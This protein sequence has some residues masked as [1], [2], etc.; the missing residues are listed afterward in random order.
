V[1]WRVASWPLDARRG[2]RRRWSGAARCR[3]PQADDPATRLATCS[4]LAPLDDRMGTRTLRPKRHAISFRI[5]GWILIFRGPG[6]DGVAFVPGLRALRPLCVSI[7]CTSFESSG[8]GATYILPRPIM[9][10]RI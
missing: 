2:G 10:L 5:D 1:W 6:A 3:P 8:A 9:C 7:L 4:G